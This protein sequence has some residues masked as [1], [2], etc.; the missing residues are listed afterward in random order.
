MDVEQTEEDAYLVVRNNLQPKTST[1]FSSRLGLKNIQSRYQFLSAAPV[2]VGP[3]DTSFEVKLP[4]INTNEST[5]HR[6]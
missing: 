1:E 3:T 6:R 2:I 5:H 4:L